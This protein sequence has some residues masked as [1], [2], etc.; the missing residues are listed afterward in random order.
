MPRL[1]ALALAAATAVT[2]ADACVK[3]VRM[4]YD[5]K[6]VAA[7]EGDGTLVAADGTRCVVPPAT[8]DA[9]RVGDDRACAW[10]NR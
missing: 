7:K 2:L 10:R 5:T 6:R 4:R 8:F 9:T 3:P 1:P